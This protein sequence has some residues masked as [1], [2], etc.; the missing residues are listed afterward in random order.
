MH[1]DWLISAS[2]YKSDVTLKTSLTFVS[3]NF[4]ASLTFV[5]AQLNDSLFK[6][7]MRKSVGMSW[8]G[9]F[10]PQ[11][12]QQHLVKLCFFSIQNF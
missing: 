1:T 5:S 4:C 3:V 11:T 8:P 10:K 9:W 6:F 7:F 12:E 2:Y